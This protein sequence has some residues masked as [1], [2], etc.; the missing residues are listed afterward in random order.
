MNRFSEGE[1]V[2]I[3]AKF[4]K[5]HEN[6]KCQIA[7]DS[8]RTIE[9]DIYASDIL[10]GTDTATEHAEKKAWDI[11][12]ELA[13]ISEGREIERKGHSI[14]RED[15]K[16]LFGNYELSWI[17]GNYSPRQI[18]ESLDKFVEGK[19]IRPGDYAEVTGIED[20]S[21]GL[22]TNVRM[23]GDRRMCTILWKDGSASRYEAR[24]LHKTRGSADIDSILEQIRTEGENERIRSQREEE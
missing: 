13:I 14:G 8:D 2:F 22:V 24:H 6:G 16:F 19:E 3:A 10:K 9:V 18:A 20:R 17:F 11:A 7:F 4:I 23:E 21:P 1:R 12:H 5:D 15:L